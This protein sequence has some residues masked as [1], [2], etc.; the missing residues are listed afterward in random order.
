MMSPAPSEEHSEGAVSRETTAMSFPE[1]DAV[2]AWL[3]P[4]LPALVRYGHLL[5]TAGVERGL[6]GPREVPRLWQR[7]LLNC[8][9]VAEPGGLVA[10]GSSVLDIGSGAGLPGLVWAITRPDCH[11]TLAEPLLRRVEFLHEVVT[12]LDLA[13][14]VTVARA[15]A[16]DLILQ[17]DVVTAR[18]VAPLTRLADWAMPSV[19]VGGSLLALKGDR[20]DDEVADARSALTAWGATEIDVVSC[21]LGVVDPPTTVVRVLRG[22]TGARGSA[23][24]RPV[25]VPSSP[26]RR[27]RRTDPARTHTPGQPPG[28]HGERS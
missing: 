18:A 1:P 17:A 7:H 3:V 25:R 9:V 4:S 19:R 11:V 6:L 27:G 8:A 23:P 24:R 10:N 15:R 13:P 21:G 2:P 20:A 16:E 5:A 22:Q 28:S 12:A 14:R 26:S